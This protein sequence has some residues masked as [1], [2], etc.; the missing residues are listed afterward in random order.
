MEKN[1]LYSDYI[2]NKDNQILYRKATYEASY[3]SLIVRCSYRWGIIPTTHRLKA[4]NN[5][6]SY[7][8]FY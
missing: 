2:N 8:V 1:Q 7:C 5:N 6:I 3:N 4:K